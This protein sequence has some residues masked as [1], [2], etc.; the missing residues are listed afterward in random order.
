MDLAS[1][2]LVFFIDL[3]HYY[4]IKLVYLHPNSILHISIFWPPLWGV[5]EDPFLPSFIICSFYQESWIKVAQVRWIDLVLYL[6]WWGIMS[7]I[8]QSHFGGNEKNLGHETS[9]PQFC[10]VIRNV[11]QCRVPPLRKNTNYCRGGLTP[12]VYGVKMH[13]AGCQDVS[14]PNILFHGQLAKGL[15]HRGVLLDEA[16]PRDTF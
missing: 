15:L 3:L 7:P 5:F 6:E 16:P 12:S 13:H 11:I 4:H 1:Q 8:Y 2:S 10:N 14:A 9:W